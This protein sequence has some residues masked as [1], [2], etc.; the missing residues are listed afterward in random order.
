MRISCGA[1]PAAS[2]R[3]AGRTSGLPL[4]T[5]AGAIPPLGLDPPI[6]HVQLD[7]GFV[8]LGHRRWWKLQL[9]RQEAA[10]YGQQGLARTEVVAEIQA[11]NPKIAVEEAVSM[12]AERAETILET[13]AAGD[14]PK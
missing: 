14:G 6:R 1:L 2:G 10:G 12:A 5:A 13:G 8:D 7:D 4:L 9:G 11:D 3:R